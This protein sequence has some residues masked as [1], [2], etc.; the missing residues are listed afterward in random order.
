MNPS[1]AAHT[2]IERPL[3]GIAA[4]PYPR[5]DRWLLER[6]EVMF[7]LNLTEEQV[8]HLV[9]TQLLPIR[10]EGEERFCSRDL[11]NLIDTYKFTASRR[12]R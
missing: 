8:Q 10:I 7:A 2:S 5:Y 9:D 6:G 11:N 12:A 3:P 1:T 4:S